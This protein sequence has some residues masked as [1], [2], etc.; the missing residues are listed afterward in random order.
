MVIIK[1]SAAQ[2]RIQAVS[3]L[4]IFAGAGGAGAAGVVDSAGAVTTGFD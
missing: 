2:V 4:S 3:P 1:T